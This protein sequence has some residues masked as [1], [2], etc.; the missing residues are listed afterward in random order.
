VPSAALSLETNPKLQLDAE[1]GMSQLPLTECRGGREWKMLSLS[2]SHPIPRLLVRNEH[3]V[4]EIPAVLFLWIFSLYESF[5][6]FLVV[7]PPVYQRKYR[8]MAEVLEKKL[9]L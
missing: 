4:E 1:V 7:Y 8:V 5:F 2:F 6:L 9:L 3:P